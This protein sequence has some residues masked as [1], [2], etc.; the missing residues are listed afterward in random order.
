MAQ[1][2]LR[3]TPDDRI[4]PREEVYHH[5]RASL[6]DRRQLSVL[7]VNISVSG[8]MLRSDATVA[9]GEWVRVWLPVVGDATAA[10]RWVLGGRIG[11]QFETPIAATKYHSV[12]AAMGR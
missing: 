1:G 3:G 7:I 2:A 10:V 11:C 12:L 9:V 4:E 6:A 8:L 5:T